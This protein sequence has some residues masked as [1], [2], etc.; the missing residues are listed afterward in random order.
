MDDNKVIDVDYTPIR[1]S[2]NEELAA[3]ANSLYESM[4]KI[5]YMG[6]QMAAEAGSA[7]KMVK[8]RLGHGQWEDWCNDNLTFGPR[9]ANRMMKLSEKM[10][11]ESSFFSNPSALTDIGITKVWALLA[12]P[13]EAAEEIVEN[14]ESAEMTTREFQEELDRIKAKNERLEACNEGFEAIKAELNEL[15]DAPDKTVELNKKI[16]ELKVKLK[17]AK[18]KAMEEARADTEKEIKK[19]REE[20]AKIATERFA[21]TEKEVERLKKMT[22]PTVQ[23]FKMSADVLQESFNRCLGI[24]E[25][26]DDPERFKQAL[27]KLVAVMDGQL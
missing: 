23:Q 21:D 18:E 17:N 24:A 2:T 3:K 10:V 1:E 27:K 22:D 16:A 6:L 13:E 12:A 19:A 9:K 14:P 7:L 4:Q 15:K 26:S 25:N 5:G 20:G 11:D 8:N